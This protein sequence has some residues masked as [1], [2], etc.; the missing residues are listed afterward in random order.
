MEKNQKQVLKSEMS[1]IEKFFEKPKDEID[2]G[3]LSEYKI[4]YKLYRT[5]GIDL[6]KTVKEENGFDK[7][8]EFCNGYIERNKDEVKWLTK[9]VGLGLPLVEDEKIELARYHIAL[10]YVSIFGR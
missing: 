8:V 4:G 9:K 6:I 5:M 2:Q 7:A 3:E 10:S 1:E